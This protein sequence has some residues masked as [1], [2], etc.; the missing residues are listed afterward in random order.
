MRRKN[1]SKNSFQL[2]KA[3]EVLISWAIILG[4]IAA[5]I[6]LNDHYLHLPIG[7][8]YECSGVYEHNCGDADNIN[9]GDYDYPDRPDY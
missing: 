6:W 8:S 4:L 3:I 5:F 2:P 1:S 9:V 7:G